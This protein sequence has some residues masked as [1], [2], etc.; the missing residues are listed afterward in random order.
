MSPAEDL[1]L[2]DAS[3]S[4]GPLQALAA[5]SRKYRNLTDAPQAH[6]RVQLAVIAEIR[7][8]HVPWPADGTGP[9]TCV[10][11]DVVVCA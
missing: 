11:V 5:E 4:K 9:V 6:P 2:S 1:L 10:E 7:V 8:G 3:L